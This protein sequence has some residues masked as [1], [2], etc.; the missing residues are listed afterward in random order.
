MK[1]KKRIHIAPVGFEVDRIVLP[2]IDYD[3]DIVYLLVHNNKADDKAGPYIK[4]ITDEL[5][6]NKIEVEKVFT[7]WRDVESIT[8]E[9][10]KLFLELSGNDIYVNIASGSKNHAIALDRAIMTL[11]DQSNITEFYAES[12]A[13]EGFKPGKQ[14]LSK[15]VREVKEIPKRKM[16]LPNKRLLGAM[17]IIRDYNENEHGCTRE[18]KKDHKHIKK[19]IKKKHLAAACIEKGVLPGAGNILTSLDKNIIQKLENEWD[20]ILVEKIGQS[21]YVGLTP[22]GEAHVHEMTS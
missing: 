12:E 20:F 5:K 11:D 22:Q 15:G 21:Y 10:R 17:T 1:V 18:C 4:R 7:N 2:A 13:Y 6:K 16:V 14:Q 19:K 3:A 9:A 8:K